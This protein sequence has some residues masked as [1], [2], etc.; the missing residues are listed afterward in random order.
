MVALVAAVVAGA[1]LPDTRPYHVEC[2]IVQTHSNKQAFLGDP[3]AGVTQSTTCELRIFSSPNHVYLQLTSKHVVSS[4]SLTPWS[5]N[6]SAITGADQLIVSNRPV[7]TCRLT[8]TGLTLGGNRRCRFS[9]W[10]LSPNFE[11]VVLWLTHGTQT[12]TYSIRSAAIPA[13]TRQISR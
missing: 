5:G 13:D 4:F 1:G 2:Q 7:T 12:T 8:S 9:L 10:Q 3:G 6:T 11:G